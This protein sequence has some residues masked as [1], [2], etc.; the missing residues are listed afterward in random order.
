MVK[1]YLKQ[2]THLTKALDECRDGNDVP[3]M[4]LEEVKAVEEPIFVIA[5]YLLKRDIVV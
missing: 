2:D 1:E 5:N 3:S 4:F